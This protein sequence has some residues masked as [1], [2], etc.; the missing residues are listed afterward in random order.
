MAPMLR[1]LRAVTLACGLLAATQWI[2][3]ALPTTAPAPKPTLPWID[4]DW[5]KAVATAK[6][7]KLPIFVDSWAPW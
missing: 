7:R 1:S 2:A 6:A 3:G 5:T 4:D